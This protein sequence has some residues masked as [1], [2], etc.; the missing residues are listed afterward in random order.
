MAK[1]RRRSRLILTAV[2]VLLVGGALM[3]AFWPKATMVD[4]GEVT[5]GS[6]RVTID[7]QGRTRVRDAYVVSTP[8]AGQLQRVTVQPGDPVVRGE[9]VVA[10]MHPTN[11]A[12]LDVRTREQAQ[13]AVAAA[14]AALRVAQA[15]LNAALANLDLARTELTR[16]EQL[17]ERGISSAAALDRAR[18]FARV[19]EANV[20]TAEAAIS[21]RE[22]EIANAQAQLIGFDD[23]RLAAAIGI[24]SSDIPLYAPA[25]GR[26]LRV[27]QQSETAL[28]AG[29]PI[30]EIGD[31]TS[32]LEVV[33]DLLSTDAVQVVVGSPVI[34]TDWGGQ[35]DLLGEVIRIDPFGITQFSALGVEEQRVKA[36]I[37]LTSPAEAYAGLGHGFRVEARIVVWTSDDAVIV[38]ASALFRSRGNW[39]VFTIIDNLAHLRLIKIGRNNGIEAE[40]LDGLSERDQVI[41]YPSSGLS[42]GMKVAQR[43]IN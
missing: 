15:D 31:I 21:M 41:L 34:I 36:V 4:I 16:T 40:V 7:E 19:T 17:V 32:D 18:Q 24:T 11:P 25:D 23:Q 43:V 33:V 29:T 8:V 12:A 6:M 38:P 9:T 10:H 28:P 14:E 42:A 30:M 22:A 27:M 35:T 20:D 2:A 39:A 3:V 37:A 13:A 26:I 5:R 1:A